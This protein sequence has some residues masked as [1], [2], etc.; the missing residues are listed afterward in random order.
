MSETLL[1]VDKYKP[2][3]VNEIIGNKSNVQKITQWLKDWYEIHVYKTKE[4]PKFVFGGDFL[5]A[6]CVLVSGPPGIGKTS[7]VHLIS[8]SLQYDIQEMNAS[9]ERNKSTIDKK[10]LSSQ[11]H[12][13]FKYFEKKS[14]K[15]MIMDE[16]DGM[17]TSDR[18]GISSLI[19]LLKV[20]KHPI[21]CICNDRNKPALKSLINHCLD[22]RVSRPDKRDILKRMVEISN[23]E[24]VDIEG[25]EME[26]M[27]EKSGNDIRNVIHQLQMYSY[28]N[29]KIQGDPSLKSSDQMKK[30][31]LSN[32][33]IFESSKMILSNKTP[34]QTRYD[35]YFNDYDMTSL[36]IQE[37]YLSSIPSKKEEI[38]KLKS[39]AD[40]SE[41]LSQ[42]DMVDSYSMKNTGMKD[43]TSLPYSAGLTAS[44]ASVTGG[45]LSFP[46]FP[47]YLGKYSTQRKRQRYMDEMSTHQIKKIQRRISPIEYRLDRIP[48]YQSYLPS[49]IIK[50]KDVKKTIQRLD[51]NGFDK[52]DFQEK[53]QDF[54]MGEILKEYKYETVDTKLK[55]AFTRE[56]NKIHEKEKKEK[57]TKK[58]KEKEDHENDD[59]EDNEEFN[60]EFQELNLEE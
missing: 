41:L 50:E 13:I 12:T 14:K 26:K 47:Q 32:I 27:I 31:D 22:I 39:M 48:L 19:S 30:D 3:K 55:T 11:T 17:S 42:M 24:N 23:K 25:D 53:L 35:L 52:E 38:P 40:A 1:W 60:E 58:T 56:W 46:Q 45:F 49:P 9:D 29:Q 16:V 51:E 28:T 8:E 34:F 20:S 4:K 5:G 7:M 33:S 59:E 10:I 36:F 2:K 18:G 21:I 54:Y 6:K 37:N 15:V 44:V 57:K 43:W